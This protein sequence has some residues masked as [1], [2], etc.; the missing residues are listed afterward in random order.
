VGFV[1]G[2]FLLRRVARVGI[3]SVK[4]AE[5]ADMVLTIAIGVVLGGRLGYVFFY[6]PSLLWTFSSH[7]PFWGVLALNEGGMA[8][9]GGMIGGILASAFYA[10]RHGHRW[11]FV[12]DLFA[13][14]AP[15]GLFFGRLANFVNGELYGRPVAEGSRAMAWAVKFP[16]EMHAWDPN[17]ILDQPKIEQINELVRRAPELLK[18]HLPDS[19]SDQVNA[20]IDAIQAG[21]GIVIR[22]VDPLLTPR[23]PSQIYEALMEGLLLF[24][25]LAVIWIRPRKPLVVASTFGLVY[26]LVRI[27]GEQFREPDLGIGYQF[28]GLTRGQWLS[29]PLALLSLGL[30]I[31]A[32]WRDA[33][34]MGGWMPVRNA[35]A[36]DVEARTT[37]TAP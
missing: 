28:L 4:P 23:H 37:Q 20:L 34:R 17:S 16:Q 9:H 26:A 31:F 10:W 18:G 29:V 14:A 24:L 27:F 21:N 1:I 5:V 12:L 32:L 22:V 33:P 13:F 2:Y 30:L 25:I 19:F 3:S 11:S 36:P 6:K 7:L 35:A 8:S 15:L